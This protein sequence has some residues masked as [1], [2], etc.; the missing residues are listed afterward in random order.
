VLMIVHGF[1]DVRSWP[2]VARAAR[3]LSELATRVH[4]S[5]RAR[6]NSRIGR[7]L[8]TKTCRRPLVPARISWYFQRSITVEVVFLS[9]ESG[10]C[11]CSRRSDRQR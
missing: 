10:L 7:Y 8:S 6:P 2:G 3:G 4:A 1:A 9:D 5:W 11:S